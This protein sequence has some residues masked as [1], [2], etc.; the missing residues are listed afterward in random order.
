MTTTNPAALPDSDA[1]E[2]ADGVVAA[3]IAAI[4]GSKKP[5]TLAEILAAIGVDTPALETRIA[6]LL[7]PVPG[8]IPQQLLIDAIENAVSA[9]AL[10]LKIGELLIAAQ[11]FSKTGKGPV[12][13]ASVEVA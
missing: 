2:A 10:Y 6:A 8:G 11:L 4:D 13:H 1:A 9:S 12:G 3:E 7:A 5:P